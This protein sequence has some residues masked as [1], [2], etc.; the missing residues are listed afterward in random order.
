MLLNDTCE[1]VYQRAYS[2][3]LAGCRLLLSLMFLGMASCTKEAV[4][5]RENLPISISISTDEA[6]LVEAF[7]EDVCDRF[8]RIFTSV[9]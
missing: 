5:Q 9:A 6:I 1:K 8:S 7:Y 2:T 4:K 3:L